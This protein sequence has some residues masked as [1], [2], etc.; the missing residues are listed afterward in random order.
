M[1]SL[2]DYMKLFVS[3]GPATS[4]QAYPQAEA[5]NEAIYLATRLHK[6]VKLLDAV[7]GK[8]VAAVDARGCLS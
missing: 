8:F 5:V 1:N 2:P 4:N 6:Q 3:Y 7:T